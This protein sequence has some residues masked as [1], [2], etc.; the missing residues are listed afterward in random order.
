MTARV[1]D[2]TS[3]RLHDRMSSRVYDCTITRV[4]WMHDSICAVCTT[5]GLLNCGAADCMIEQ[6]YNGISGSK[7]EY[8]IAQNISLFCVHVVYNVHLSGW[9]LI[10]INIAIMCS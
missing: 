10:L 2:C 4:L 5:S 6:K 8:L 3:S 1:Y 7:S 9:L